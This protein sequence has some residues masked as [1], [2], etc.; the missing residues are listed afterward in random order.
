MDLHKGCLREWEVKTPEAV[1]V[2][3]RGL[4]RFA[5]SKA[6]VWHFM[7]ERTVWFIRDCFNI[8]APENGLRTEY[9]LILHFQDFVM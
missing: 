7:Q 3:R 4:Q 9:L 8:V 2:M 5:G 1:P 6:D